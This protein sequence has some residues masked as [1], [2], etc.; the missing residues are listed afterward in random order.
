M[1]RYVALLRAINVGGHVV[2]MGR[3]RTLF[4]ALDLREVETFIAS[5][6]VVFRSDEKAAALEHRIAAHLE[7]ALGYEVATFI[8][9]AAQIIAIARFTPFPMLPAGA[10]LY[11]GFLPRSLSA[12]ERRTLTSLRSPVDDLRV[13]KREVYWLCR[14]RSSDAEFSPARLEKTLRL[15]ATFRNMTTI[16]KLAA[17]GT[18]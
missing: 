14:V 3:L 7:R 15:P 11:A 4:E 10:S 1:T 13:R 17:R 2:K 16:R 9:T 8:R 5:G 12:G 18:P 6:N